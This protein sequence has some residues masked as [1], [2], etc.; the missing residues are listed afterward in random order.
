MK[1]PHPLCCPSPSCRPVWGVRA[2]TDRDRR[3]A[4]EHLAHRVAVPHTPSARGPR[5]PRLDTRYG[6]DP[7]P[8]DLV[9]T[10]PP[11]PLGARRGRLPSVTGGGPRRATGRAP[12]AAHEHTLTATQPEEVTVA[13][14][15]PGSGRGAPVSLSGLG[16]SSTGVSGSIVG[17]LLPPH[18]TSTYTVPRTTLLGS[19]G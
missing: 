11:P 16:T 18:P 17:P 10:S 3:S 13:V 4:E 1:G 8:R 7:S 2:V 19:R 14:S 5:T 15:T 12:E 6:R 9:P